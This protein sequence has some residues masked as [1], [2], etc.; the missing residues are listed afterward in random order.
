MD[1]LTEEQARELRA[2]PRDEA[3]T[4][5][6][7]AETV[8]R[9]A[10]KLDQAV[11][12]LV[13]ADLYYLLVRVCKRVDMLN[14]FAFA[15]C[16]EVEAA[17]D[18]HLDLWAREHFKSSIITFGLTIQD[19]LKDPETT[20][21]IF[22]HTR[23]IAKAFLRQIMREL[24]SNK[25]LH[26]AFPDVLW[27]EDVRQAPKWSE[28]D[29]IIVRRKSNPNEA[30]IEAW[31]LVDGQPTSK[32]F[33]K[34][35]YDDVVV[36][37]SVTSPEMIQ[38]T[39]TEM[40]R[41]YNLGTTPGIKRGAGTRWHFND[42]YKTVTD[43]GT[44][45]AR[46]H[47]GRE[48]GT[49]E[50]ESVF[51]PEETHLQKR[52]DM[53]PYTYAAQILLNPKADSQMGFRR[54]WLRSYTRLSHI[55][56]M[57]TYILVDAANSKRKESDYTAIWVVGLAVDGNYYALDIVRD[58]LNLTERADRLF[59]LHRKWKPKQVRYERY[60]LMADIEHIKA[61]QEDETYRFDVTEVGGITSKDD[62]IR[63]LLPIFEGG[64]F[65]LPK[66]IHVTDWQKTTHDLVHDFIE[67]EFYPFP[68]CLHKDM[69]DSLSRIAEPAL[70]L[71]WPKEEKPYVPAPAQQIE[72]ANTAWMA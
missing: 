15:R 18:G 42:A 3:M 39:M 4:F 64:R 41:S 56:K 33:K 12:V 20:F 16:R 68:V 14:E 5:W 65:Y 21:G 53:G 62:R 58:R 1:R 23:P 59:S 29:G 67:E 19:I 69:L 22:S 38:K 57:N 36:A 24:E 7:A 66:S 71:V 40:E 43:R 13:C 27:G 11:R 31:G 61:R 54:E 8:G 25:T 48:G 63:R 34:L 10:G 45:I 9:R 2:R 47:P 37:G 72:R 26:A 6:E 17:P 60:G 44:L 46:E 52:R 51:W 70:K 49:E 55:G 32:H 30:T 28:D 50:G 35:L